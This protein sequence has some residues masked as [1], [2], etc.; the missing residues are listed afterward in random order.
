MYKRSDFIITKSPFKNK[1]Y[2]AVLKT[3]P[4]GDHVDFG[5]IRPNGTPYQQYR[6]STPLKLYSKYDHGD[7][8]RQQ[9][10]IK[11]HNKDIVDSFTAG[12]LS[13]LFLWS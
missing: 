2:R 12:C 11:R 5:A 4:D 8:D 7:K 13:Y 9:R 3:D 1:K 10:Y 6:D